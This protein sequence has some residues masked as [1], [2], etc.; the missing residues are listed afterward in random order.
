MELKI[1]RI[2]RAVSGLYS[3]MPHLRESFKGPAFDQ[4]YPELYPIF[5]ELPS[6]DVVVKS[7]AQ[8]PPG[9]V[10]GADIKSLP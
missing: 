2:A 8:V 6:G 3:L 7:Y 9:T 4:G 5:E 10:L 1:A